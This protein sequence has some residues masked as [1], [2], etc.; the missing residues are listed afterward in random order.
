[1]NLAALVAGH[2]NDFLDQRA[3]FLG[4]MRL[5]GDIGMSGS[6]LLLAILAASLPLAGAAVILGILE[7]IRLKAPEQEK[8]DLAWA[9]AGE[10]A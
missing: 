6:P 3:Q 9:F 4:G 5:C 2:E 8:I 7:G 1:M 10:N